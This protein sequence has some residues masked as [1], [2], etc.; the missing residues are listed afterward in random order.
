MKALQ[1][2]RSCVTLT[3]SV[4]ETMSFTSVRNIL[5]QISLYITNNDTFLTDMVSLL[6]RDI[7]A[8]NLTLFLELGTYAN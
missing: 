3:T 5:P 6:K 8:R 2:D 1:V 4:V 7:I